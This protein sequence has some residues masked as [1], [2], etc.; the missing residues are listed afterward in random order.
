LQRVPPAAEFQ[1][2]KEAAKKIGKMIS[3]RADF[4]A[5]VSTYSL[6]GRTAGSRFAPLR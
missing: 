3:A 6:S 2:G 1:P 4:G 5:A